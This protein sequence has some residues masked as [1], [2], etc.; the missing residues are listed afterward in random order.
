VST[1]ALPQL[2][3][4]S[5]QLLRHLPFE[6]TCSVAHGLSQPPQL[7]GLI[8]VSTHAVP[9]NANP[10]SQL[11]PQT[12]SLQTAVPWAGASQAVPH[13]LQFCASLSKLTQAAPHDVKPSAHAIPHLPAS[14]TALPLAGVGHAMP[15]SPQFSG[16]DVTSM[17]EPL[18]FVRPPEQPA[19]HFAWSHTCVAEHDVLQSPQRAGSLVTSTQAPEHS[20]KPVAHSTPQTPSWQ[21]GTP[22]PAVGQALPHVPQFVRSVAASTQL[23]PQGRKPA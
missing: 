3:L 22:P 8:L 1:Q 17:H 19:V 18:Q 16:L 13:A 12:P 11:A 7:A 15:H 2:V 23:V 6:Q 21:T 5:G 9:H 10:C 20:R 4:P 14:H